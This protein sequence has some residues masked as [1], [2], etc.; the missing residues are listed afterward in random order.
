MFL[1]LNPYLY[2]KSTCTKGRL[3]G[4]VFSMKPTANPARQA[5]FFLP[6]TTQR[7]VQSKTG[8]QFKN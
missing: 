6:F 1:D 3:S 7:T 5:K 2:I 4:K 8:I